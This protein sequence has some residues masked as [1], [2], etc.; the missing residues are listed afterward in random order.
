MFYIIAVLIVIA[1][2]LFNKNEAPASPASPTSRIYN[3][4]KDTVYFGGSGKIGEQIEN[5][6]VESCKALCDSTKDCTAF[7]YINNHPDKS[8]EKTCHLRNNKVYSDE[9]VNIPGLDF[10]YVGSIPAQ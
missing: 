10:Y 3:I 8:Y 5:Q 4:I 2:L 7:I 9:V 1:F 6:T